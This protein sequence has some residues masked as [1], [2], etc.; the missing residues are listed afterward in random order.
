MGFASGL[1]L[2]PLTDGKEWRVMFLFGAVMPVIMIGLVFTVMP[3]SPRWLVAKDRTEEARTIL[4][5]IY[6]PS[7]GVDPVLQDIRLSLERDKAAQRTIGWNTL[8]RPTPSIRRM[9]LAGVGTAVAQQAVG[10]DAIQYY[11]LDVV[12][13]L[14]IGSETKEGLVLIALGVIKLIFIVVGGLTFDSHGRRPLLFA[15]L[16]GMAV[17]LLLISLGFL[18]DSTLSAK[19]TILGLAA[20]LAFFSIGMVST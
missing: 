20:Y 16:I 8:L 14:G 7:I 5:K 13:D 6:P 17:A 10:I 12:A 11:L 19:A 9:L 18:I 1:V 3:E 2:A 15:S 4:Q